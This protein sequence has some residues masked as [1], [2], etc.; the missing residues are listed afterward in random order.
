MQ[1]NKFFIWISQLDIFY[2]VKI[3]FPV[4][5]LNDYILLGCHSQDGKV[6][7]P[8]A[9]HYANQKLEI[10]R[11]P[12]K[13]AQECSAHKICLCFLKESFTDIDSNA[14]KMIISQQSSREDK[15]SVEENN[16][17]EK[18]EETEKIVT[19]ESFKLT[20]TQF[21]SLELQKEKNC[22]LQLSIVKPLDAIFKFKPIIALTIMSVPKIEKAETLKI[23]VFIYHFLESFTLSA[24]CPSRVVINPIDITQSVA[25]GNIPKSGTNEDFKSS[26]ILDL[27]GQQVGNK[28]QYQ[29]RI[30]TQIILHNFTLPSLQTALM[31]QF[32]FISFLFFSLFF[33]QV[34]NNALLVI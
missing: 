23:P 27:E 28:S 13:S 6:I 20:E 24:S 4:M 32:Y 26:K 5:N 12:E 34:H 22:P 16:I 25:R 31:I 21:S 10:N 7:G 1:N 19:S 33:T 14:G 18:Q 9:V 2:V 30:L 11:R 29:V 15:V 3:P 8:Y 17:S